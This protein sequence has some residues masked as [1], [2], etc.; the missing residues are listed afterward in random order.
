[1]EIRNQTDRRVGFRGEEGGEERKPIEAGGTAVLQPP[2]RILDVQR[3]GEDLLV[4]TTLDPFQGGGDHDAPI[5]ALGGG[6]DH[7]APIEALGGGSDPEA[8]IA[9]TLLVN[10]GTGA[11]LELHIVRTLPAGSA[12]DIG[13][14]VAAVEF[15][16]TDDGTLKVNVLASR[17]S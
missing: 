4:Q 12:F 16:K 1:M 14:G 2:A 10:N 6:G 15:C 7:D 3:D 11:P 13:G 9:S 8:G 5:E 17:Q